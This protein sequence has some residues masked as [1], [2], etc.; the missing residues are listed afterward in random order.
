MRRFSLRFALVGAAIVAAC[1]A[2]VLLA[3]G[4]R[5]RDA[6][7]SQH[8]FE[9]SRF[10]VC[11]YDPARHT[12]RL[13]SRDEAGAFYRSFERLEAALGEDT[14]RVRF[15]MNA[16]MFND[17]GAPIG[18]YIAD[19]VRLHRLRLTDG[20][21][22]FHLKPNGV[23]WVDETGIPHVTATEVYAALPSHARW[24]TQSGPMLV[25]DGALHPRFAANGESRLVRNG[26]G[27][28]ANGRA[29]FV[30]SGAVS[31]GRF[32]RFFRDHLDC[33]NA[34]FFDGAVSSLWAPRSNRRDSAHPLGPMVV[35]SDR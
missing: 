20:P 31:F 19:G 1:V 18:L 2:L 21:G 33:P 35:V 16:G 8:R 4:A 23:F 29:Y 6:P 13:V 28:D 7:C 26:V 30:L 12:L 17:A 34:L 27:V 11:V 32:A 5:S 24:A 25:I 22:N 9:G 14:H 15:A 3:P 10:T